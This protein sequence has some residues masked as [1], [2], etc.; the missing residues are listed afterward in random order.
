MKKL[1]L[2]STILSGA[3]FTM[4]AQENSPMIENAPGEE[5]LYN[6][7]IDASFYLGGNV[8]TLKNL[9][10][11]INFADNKAY[12][13]N[14]FSVQD[15]VGEY[16]TCE[17]EDNKIY[18]PTGFVYRDFGY[19]VA[20]VMKFYLD[21]NDNWTMDTDNSPI[22]WNINEDG[23]ISENDPNVVMALVSFYD[24]Y[25][26]WETAVFEEIS[27]QPA[28]IDNMD[29]PEN[30]TDIK[31]YR[32]FN[33]Y[34]YDETY[35]NTVFEIAS[36]GNDFYF[37]GL[38]DYPDSMDF[39]CWIKGT[40][41]GNTITIPNDQII[42]VDKRGYFCY[43]ANAE[44]DMMTGDLLLLDQP[45]NLQYDKAAN[46]M[47]TDEWL[48]SVQGTEPYF[49]FPAPVITP[50]ELKEATPAIPIFITLDDEWFDYFGQDT[51]VFLIPYE[52]TDG[53][54][55]NPELLSYSIFIDS[56]EPYVFEPEEYQGLYEPQSEF[57][58]YENTSFMF[59]S[60][61][62]GYQ[63]HLAYIN[64]N[65]FD[66][67]GVQ[68]Y[69]TVNGVKNASEILWYDRNTSAIGTS[70]SNKEVSA[71]ETYDLMGKK[72]SDSSKGLVIKKVIYSDGTVKS[73]KQIVK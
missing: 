54:F 14:L 44:L 68:S 38:Y 27:M 49:Y 57:D 45:V 62:E 9:C 24:E 3:L 6:T 19:G 61:S 73:L 4:K 17:L 7:T 40:L 26:Y 46:T 18:L 63:R 12:I 25:D 20:K 59:N 48:L 21:E 36:D 15:P 29:L 41:E 2:I 22:I 8:T 71:I 50:F 37:K 34:V 39:L 10:Y 47:T 1:L 31:Y 30:I 65:S 51:F 32:R 16:V 28:V 58:F 69:Y 67:I 33:E 42:G 53:N 70:I 60:P 5:K 35:L 23:S 64:T 72:V 56:A 13:Y 66:K 11:K 52:D 43:N 55:I